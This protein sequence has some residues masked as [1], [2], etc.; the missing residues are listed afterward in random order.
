MTSGHKALALQPGIRAELPR[1]YT[2]ALIRT[3]VDTWLGMFALGT[4]MCHYFLTAGS[5]KSKGPHR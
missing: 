5:N 2:L 4:N 3:I 1:T